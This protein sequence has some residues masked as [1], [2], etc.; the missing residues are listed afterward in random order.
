MKRNI[1][2]ILILCFA[3]ATNAQDIVKQVEENDTVV[4]Q[5]GDYTGDI[6]WQKSTDNT[7]W[8]DLSDQTMDSLKF[9]VTEEA[10]Y[11]ASVT[12]GSCDPFISEVTQITFATGFVCGTSI[13]TD[14]DG[15]EYKTVEI[16][17]QCWMAENLKTTR[18]ANGA[19][20][21]DGTGAG[22]IE[23]DFITK[24]YFWYNDDSAAHFTV[25]GALY[26]WAAAMNGAGA[27]SANPSGVQGACPDGWHLPSDAEWDTLKASL[28][29]E[30]GKKLKST[31]DNWKLYKNGTN[32][33]GFTGEPSGYR[34]YYKGLFGDYGSGAY[35]W[36]TT[37]SSESHP[38]YRK[39]TDPSKKLE[40]WE[41]SKAHGMSVRCVKN[42]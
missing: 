19:S 27:T 23:G 20:M 9:M 28:G 34:N 8:T 24:Y 10:Y 40:R 1:S 41:S 30:A 39:L 4:L 5:L 2:W 32:S 18:Y 35:Y 17:D 31:S 16:G 7:V 12:A 22:D 3:F 6:Q 11:R 37:V 25:D 21:V 33:S 26:T 14:V 13:I 42:K 15:N 29:S 38:W 36:S